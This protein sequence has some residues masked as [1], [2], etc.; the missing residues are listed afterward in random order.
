MD[1][2]LTISNLDSN[3]H[4]GEHGKVS[5]RFVRKGAAIA[6]SLFLAGG[7]SY[8]GFE[9]LDSHSLPCGAELENYEWTSIVKGYE[10]EDV[11][12]SSFKPQEFTLF[13][14]KYDLDEIPQEVDS[15]GLLLSVDPTIKDGAIVAV[16]LSCLDR[17]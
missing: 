11:G 1:K 12:W 4:A 9:Y 17:E 7:L 8:K 14:E 2:E 16:K 5:N 13:A 10:G 3:T 6:V 15:R